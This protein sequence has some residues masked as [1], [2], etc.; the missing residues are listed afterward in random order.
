[1]CVV[2]CK[3]KTTTAAGSEGVTFFAQKFLI[4][5][6]FVNK[7]TNIDIKNIIFALL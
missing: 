6:I 5:S 1:M 4:L 2:S 3:T 7:Y